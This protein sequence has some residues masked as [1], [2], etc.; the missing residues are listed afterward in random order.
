MKEMLCMILSLSLGGTALAAV[1]M[2][3]QR[4]M[5]MRLP[6]GFAYYAWLLVLLRFVLPLP[7]LLPA[8]ETAAPRPAEPLPV[9]TAYPVTPGADGF[10]PRSYSDHNA[11]GYTFGTE[12]LL[13]GTA[14]VVTEEKD[15]FDPA[16]LWEA[17]RPVLTSWS[18]WGWLYLAGAGLSLLR[19]GVGYVR[20][21]RAL[22]STFQPARES[23]R[24]VLE[25]LNPTPW[26]ALVRSRAVRTPMLFGLLRPVIV[27]PDRGYD[28]G[29]LRGILRHELTHYRRGDLAYKWFAV[30]VSCLHWFNPF[31][32]IFRREIDRACELSCDERLLRRMDRDEKQHYGELLLTLAAD[33]PLPGSV[34]AMSFATEKRNLKER[35][36]Q[37]MKYKNRGRAGLALAL[38]AILL[39]SGCGAALGP[40]L[41]G[42]ARTAAEPEAAS[43]PMPDVVVTPFLAD[44]G[45]EVPPTPMPDTA[46]GGEVTELY[47]DN[48]PEEHII[49]R[50]VDE[51][52]AA[53]G[54]D[55]VIQLAGGEYNLAGARS[56]GV[57]TG[58]VNVR[59]ED[60]GD[61]KQLVISQVQ[62]LYIV[63]RDRALTSIVTE[64]RYAN[65]LSFENS[66]NVNLLSL[67]AG[68]TAAPGYCTGGVLR[69]DSCDGMNV[70]GCGLYGCGI[71]G[72]Q[73]KNCRGVSVS[74]TDVY[75][76]SVGAIEADGCWDVR[77][78]SGAV[79]HC[80]QKGDPI[81]FDLFRAR[82]TTGFAVF[83]VDIYDNR[84]QSLLHSENSL[85]VQM[86]G[87][88]VHDNS[89]STPAEEHTRE[90][91]SRFL[92]ASGGLFHICGDSPVI[93][94][95]CF[96]K[97]D[98]QGKGMYF[99]Y[100][101]E[102]AGTVVS[103]E[104][105]ELALSDLYT[106]EQKPY[107]EPYY[108]PHQPEVI[109]T[110]G[111]TNELGEKV[112][113]VD[114]ADDFLAAIGS[115]TTVYV[116]CELLDLS[117]ASSY[118]GYGGNNYY[119]RNEFDG[120]NLVITGVE[121][122]HVI[123]QGK[124]VTTLQAV[125]RYAEVLNFDSCSNVSVEKLTA[126]HLKEAPGSCAG[127]VLEFTNCGE[128]TVKDCGLFGCGV[129]GIMANNCEGL[130]VEDTEIYE[131]SN[132]GAQFGSCTGVSFTGCYIHDCKY[133][134]IFLN[135]CDLVSWNGTALR[136]GMN[137]VA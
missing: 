106:M 117:T 72:V 128:I 53:I 47:G 37:I 87:C 28:E 133:D 23:D 34:V 10:A 21:R 41:T 126:G 11:S 124:D 118:G 107:T 94:D 64:P 99:N 102:N 60:I 27:L 110:G 55:R 40:N 122:F 80:G 36:L 7:G 71:L 56:Y 103:A 14:A 113:H 45:N 59:W 125:P 4:V 119:W 91:G 92:W 3:L 86:R 132:M 114:N 101:G 49:V 58:N 73:A 130:T 97:N 18:F 65:V 50:T 108:G 135:H 24:L 30:L 66:A 83:N 82:A 134:G 31:L 17:A 105:E 51:F 95:C 52:I 96:T 6:A 33:R 137:N 100:D 2:L 70:V 129:N 84:A 67:T 29:M 26:P 79:Y 57:D 136:D 25:A 89:F 15:A 77:M 109:P 12:E 121:N 32:A 127:D 90:D 35:L 46:D 116:D 120:P 74:L 13:P 75:D 63:G 85:E 1:L 19:Y 98:V 9:V 112:F 22:G 44:P 8:A 20:F 61:G 104:G 78:N 42:A 43:A 88:N 123:G 39:L 115:D 93:A 62:N 5:K 131:C 81:A 54:S 69:F 68:H 111:E 48:I 16:A 76:C 38:A